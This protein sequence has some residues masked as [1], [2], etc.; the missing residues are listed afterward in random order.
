M[1]LPLIGIGSIS[2]TGV[3][4]LITDIDQKTL[5][6][7]TNLLQ[8]ALHGAFAIGFSGIA[9]RLLTKQYLLRAGRRAR[10]SC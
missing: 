3:F 1:F 4:H 10:L 9:F 8:M 2:A 5:S 6:Q 7:A